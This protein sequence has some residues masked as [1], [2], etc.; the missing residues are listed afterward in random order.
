MWGHDVTYNKK[1]YDANKAHQYYLRHRQLK[2]YANRYGGSRGNGT[3]AASTP[4]FLSDSKKQSEIVSSHNKSISKQISKLSSDTSTN[5][6][7]STDKSGIRIQTAKKISGIQKRIGDLRESLKKMSTEDRKNNKETIQK[8]IDQ[9]RGQIK[10]VRE[11][12]R[13]ALESVS[14][15]AHASN[16]ARRDAIQ[17]LRQQTKGGSTSGF[18]KKGKQAAARIKEQLNAERDTLTRKTN[19]NLDRKMLGGVK[20]LASQISKYRQDGGSYS[21]DDLLKQIN[22]M[23]SRTNRAKTNV[24]RSNK[25]EFTQHYKNSVDKLRTDDSNFAYWDKRKKA[26][27]K[28]AKQKKLKAKIRKIMNRYKKRKE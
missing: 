23:A 24:A 25:T 3:S 2:G 5:E 20:R 1:Y 11:E 17:R 8:Q 14:D 19:H 28:R 13:S 6:S 27:R 15:T 18:N 10:A 16:L 4:G 12:Q 22:A 26:E 9:L 7:A 21:N